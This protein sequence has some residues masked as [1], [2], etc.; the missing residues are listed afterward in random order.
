[1]F[2]KLF[3]IGGD[4]AGSRS[5]EHPRDLRIGDM[6]KTGLDE[7]TDLSDTDFVVQKVTGLD[8]SAKSGFE[9]RIFHLGQTKS[10]FPLV[11][12]VDKEKGEER[13]AFAYGADQPHVESQ[14]N[15]DQFVELFDPQ[16]NH[17]VVVDA[18][19][20]AMPENPWL[21]GHYVQDQASEVYWL[22]ADP[23]QKQA[24]DTLS[25]DEQACDY[26]RLSSA[27]G[28]AAIEVFIFDG[29]KTDVYFV[30]HLPLYKI[31]ELMPAKNGSIG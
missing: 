22:D 26:F 4:Q 6:F 11:L 29:G 23:L 13:L 31:E 30:K 28:N 21:A 2:R 17:L 8:L 5:L 7:H 3:G 1:M 18:L 12:W 16:R 20:L 25:N 15:M 27:D 24:G 19:P 14:L 10:G 9:R